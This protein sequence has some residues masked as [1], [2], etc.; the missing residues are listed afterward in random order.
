MTASGS[1]IPG[2]GGGGNDRNILEL[3]EV[4][5]VQDCECPTCHCVVKMVTCT[6]CEYPINKLFKKETSSGAL[7][8]GN[9]M[10]DKLVPRETVNLRF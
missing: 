9:L 8:L 2:G 10:Q 5:V 4:V 1:R 6:L 7:H 3:D